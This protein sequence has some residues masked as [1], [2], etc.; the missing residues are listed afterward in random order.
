MVIRIVVA[1][2]VVVVGM[3]EEDGMEVIVV[4]VVG[5]N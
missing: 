4:E 2:M 1:M 3:T 5:E